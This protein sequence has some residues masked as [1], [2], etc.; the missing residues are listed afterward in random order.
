[1]SASGPGRTAQNPATLNVVARKKSFAE[2]AAEYSTLAFLLPASAFAG[3][4]LGGLLDKAFGTGYLQIVCLL[5]GI[6][7]GFVQLIRQVIQD[8]HDHDE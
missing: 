6:V 5:A 7:G 8:T 4:L 2:Q 1:M 3:W